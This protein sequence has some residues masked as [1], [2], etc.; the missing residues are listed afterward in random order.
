[1]SKKSAIFS[2]AGG[3]GNQ[4]FQ[5]SAAKSI[6]TSHSIYFET[7]SLKPRKHKKGITEIESL[8]VFCESPS[9][10]LSANSKMISKLSGYLLSRGSRQNRES[11][12]GKTKI[13]LVSYTLSLVLFF[14]YR[15]YFKIYVSENVGYSAVNLANSNYWILGYFQ[16]Y[17]YIDNSVL[18]QINNAELED[19]ST[20]FGRLMQQV[21]EEKP[22]L[23]HL[24]LGDYL[25]ER[26]F[27]LPSMEYYAAAMSDLEH[28]GYNGPYWIFSDDLDLAKEKLA[29]ITRTNYR[30][31]Q[32]QHLS[33]AEVLKIMSCASHFIIANSTF[34][35]W[36][37]ML[38]RTPQKRVYSPFPWFKNLEE[39]RRLI[40][41]EWT[42]IHSEN[43]VSS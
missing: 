38:S 14:F 4:L 22:C 27:G 24:R 18:N 25:E 3:L 33:S 5:Y 15:K 1:M 9:S 40:P 20:D 37:A 23:I 17:E 36:S 29:S 7:S 35:Y 2:L 32:T 26:D 43:I 41:Q 34:S 28:S 6:S 10:L 39:P 42:R 16:S 8:G 21:L 12:V 11:L 13:K 31:I 30:F 19:P